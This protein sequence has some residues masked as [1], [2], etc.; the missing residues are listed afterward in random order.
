MIVK[1]ITQGVQNR[2]SETVEPLTNQLAEKPEDVFENASNF[3]RYFIIKPPRFANSFDSDEEILK[4]FS[5]ETT[6]YGH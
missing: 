5:E 6:E 2:D 1:N 4:S 3:G